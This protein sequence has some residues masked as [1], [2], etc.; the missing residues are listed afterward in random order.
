MTYRNH[1]ESLWQA[2]HKPQMGRVFNPERERYGRIKAPSDMNHHDRIEALQLSASR[3]ANAALI[4]KRQ[5][6]NAREAFEQGRG[7][8]DAVSAAEADYIESNGRALAAME[9]LDKAKEESS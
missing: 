2:A 9:R 1:N 5:L 6:E 4:K 8:W 7:E 3:M